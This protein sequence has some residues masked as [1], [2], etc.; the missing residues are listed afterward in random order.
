MENNL[1]GIGMATHILDKAQIFE[2]NHINLPPE[3]R[4]IQAYWSYGNIAPRLYF[5]A[6][7]VA[8][9]PHDRVFRINVGHVDVANNTLVGKHAAKWHTTCRNINIIDR[10]THCAIILGLHRQLFTRE[11]HFSAI[12]KP[13][14][15]NTEIYHHAVYQRFA[16]A[17]LPRQHTRQIRRINSYFLSKSI[18]CETRKLDEIADAVYGI[19]RRLR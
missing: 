1:S 9:Y 17:R 19:G 8:A 4:G 16:G 13:I 7:T 18:L 11:R 10:S 15:R 14:F 12:N 5:G 6:H 2:Y 3:N